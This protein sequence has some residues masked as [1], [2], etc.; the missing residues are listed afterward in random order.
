VARTFNIEH[1]SFANYT[2]VGRCVSV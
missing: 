2:T 1:S